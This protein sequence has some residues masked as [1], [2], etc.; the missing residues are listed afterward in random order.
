MNEGDDLTKYGHRTLAF[1][2]R[3]IR[4]RAAPHAAIA[5]AVMTAVACSVSTQYGV[6][7]LVD[8]LSAP[9]KNG[10]PWFAFCILLFFIAADN[11]FWRVA[12]LVGSYTF[13][14][15]TGDIRADLFRHLTGHAPGYFAKRM[16]GMLTSRVTA[17][18]NAVFTIENMFVRNVAPPCLAT[19]GAIGF[20]AMVNGWM[21]GLL[22]VVSCGM[23][24]V[25]FHIAAAGKPLHHDFADKAAAVDGEM[26]DVIGNISL[27]KAFGGLSREQR[28]FDATVEQELKARR[29]SLLYLERLRLTHAAVTVILIVGLLAWVIRLWQRHEATVGD[30]VLVCTLGVSVLSATRDFAVALGRCHATLRS[31]VGGARYLAL[32]ARTHG[33]PA[34]G[35]PRAEWRGDHR[36]RADQLRLSR[37]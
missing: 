23:I 25:I 26:I 4:A 11:L 1:L 31:S 14:R 27:V 19:I 10:S 13:V 2:G 12:G 3:Y 37:E 33:S 17:T 35:R 18:S 30:V 32:A 21:A 16:P 34:S 24:V 22:A 8:A 5:L 7:R 6:K 29:R 36:L 20:L 28:R 15:V 9:S